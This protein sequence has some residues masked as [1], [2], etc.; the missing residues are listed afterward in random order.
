MVLIIGNPY[1]CNK[2]LC[3]KNLCTCGYGALSRACGVYDGIFVCH[4]K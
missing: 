4:I 3:T 2:N 1:L